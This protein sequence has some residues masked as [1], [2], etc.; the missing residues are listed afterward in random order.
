MRRRKFS[1]R[2]VAERPL[3]EGHLVILKKCYARGEIDREA[4]GR[5]TRKWSDPTG[6]SATS[7]GQTERLGRGTWK[8]GG[9]R[10]TRWASVAWSLLAGLSVFGCTEAPTFPP[11]TL[12][13]SMP[14][15]LVQRPVTSAADAAAYADEYD[16]VLG[17]G[18]VRAVRV[19]GFEKVYW[20]YVQES[21]TGRPAFTLAVGAD[22]DLQVRNFPGMEPE[23]MWNQK[24]GH[25]ARPTLDRME[26]GLSVAEA[27]ERL[28][29]ALPADGKMKPGKVSAY[30]GYFLFPL[31][32]ENRLVGEGAVDAVRREVVW[33]PFPE[34]PQSTWLAPGVN[35]RFCE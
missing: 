5:M 1:K 4:Y 28:R 24:Y 10:V 31:C 16:R 30:Y 6:S 21:T 11:R 15:G 13:G 35:E 3:G 2:G 20:V 9:L 34:P 27:T 22:G 14:E 25:E 33:K 18:D 23:M 7:V 19:L 26:S 29:Q 17:V 12:V 8:R 32:E